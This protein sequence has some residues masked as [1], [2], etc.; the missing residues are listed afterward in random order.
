MQNIPTGA[1]PLSRRSLLK[2]GAA[3]GAFAF[4]PGFV[5]SAFAQDRA[6]TLV[7][8]AP[9]TPLSLDVENSLSLGT[10]DTVA[11]F[12]DY[13]VAFNTVPDTVEG[14]FDPVT[15]SV[16][17]IAHNIDSPEAAQFVI[18]HELFGHYG[19]RGFF[20]RDLDSVL[21]GIWMKNQNVR[22]EAAALTKKAAAM[23]FQVANQINPLHA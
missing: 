11:A 5:T 18:F 17:L 14:L 21:G 8:A 3:A 9:A 4:A 10:I 19:L 12:Y 22:K 20:G 13:L 15:Q 6:K 7:I 16:H 1:I 23:F 2:Y